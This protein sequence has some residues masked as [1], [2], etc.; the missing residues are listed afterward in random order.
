MGRAAALSTGHCSL[1]PGASCSFR[2]TLCS[3]GFASCPSA[4]RN[5]SGGFWGAQPPAVPTQP[6]GLAV[7]T[8]GPL[9]A[10]PSPRHS[11][12]TGRSGGRASS[13]KAAPAALGLIS[14]EI[15]KKKKNTKHRR[16]SQPGGCC[17]PHCI[18][19]E[20]RVGVGGKRLRWSRRAL[21]SLSSGGKCSRRGSKEK[22]CFPPRRGH[23][24][25]GFL[26]GTNR[27]GLFREA[28]GPPGPVQ[29]PRSGEKLPGGRSC[30]PVRVL[31]SGVMPLGRWKRSPNFSAPG[32]RA[33]ASLLINLS[34]N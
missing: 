11:M 20:P 21:P 23:V 32:W 14:N 18:P 29:R 12:L 27:G 3:F 7:E 10:R 28:E 26:R 30:S 33:T 15:K 17:H 4:F 16:W 6:W 13:R 25:R 1:R 24:N 5:P 31:G 19:S 2:L 22:L 8:S 9:P 34:G